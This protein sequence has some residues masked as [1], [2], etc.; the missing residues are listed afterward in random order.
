M[1]ASSSQQFSV[2][3]RTESSLAVVLYTASSWA[4]VSPVSTV[5]ISQA[6]VA[7]SPLALTYKQFQCFTAQGCGRVQVISF[8][9]LY[10][11]RC[12]RHTHLSWGVSHGSRV[13]FLLPG[14]HFLLE[15][16][17]AELQQFLVHHWSAGVDLL[18][19]PLRPRRAVR[20]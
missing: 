5:L 11:M 14:S 10:S 18:S 1:R 7:D 6:C 8:R 19:R 12:L 9:V 17:Y 2:M 13:S 15:E 3:L 16:T 20:C 4:S